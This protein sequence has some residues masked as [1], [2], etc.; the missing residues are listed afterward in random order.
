MK[1]RMDQ[2]GLKP[3][4]VQSTIRSI[5]ARGASK[6]P[7]LGLVFAPGEYASC[8]AIPFRSVRMYNA[9]ITLLPCR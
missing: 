8:H 1:F 7:K 2:V 5:A 9:T 4:T 3:I 6:I